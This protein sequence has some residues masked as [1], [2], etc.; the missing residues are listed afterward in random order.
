MS[1]AIG[2]ELTPDERLERWRPVVHWTA[3][4]PLALAALVLVP[5][6]VGLAIVGAATV[7]TTGRWPDHP[8]RRLVGIHRFQYRVAT[9]LVLVRRQRPSWTLTPTYDDPGGDPLRFDVPRPDPAHRWVP[10][11][12]GV[13]GLPRVVVIAVLSIGG[14]FAVIVGAVSIVVRG[15]WPHGLADFVVAVARCQAQVVAFVESMVDHVPRLVGP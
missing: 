15:R 11:A 3:G 12:R 13:L 8:A 7:L 6:A 1:R 14:V 9:Y 2:F 4:L 5:V 10:L